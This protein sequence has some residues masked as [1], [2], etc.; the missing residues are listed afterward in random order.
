MV[1]KNDIFVAHVEQHLKEMGLDHVICKI[2]NK[3]IDEIYKTHCFGHCSNCD[4]DVLFYRVDTGSLARWYCTECKKQSFF[5]G[6]N[7]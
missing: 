4:K 3:T 5:L 7:K 2:C 1:E 6:K